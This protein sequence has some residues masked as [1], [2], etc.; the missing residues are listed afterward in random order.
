VI[1]NELP[2][3]SL[4]LR[5]RFSIVVVT[6]YQS[7]SSSESASMILADRPDKPALAPT[8]SLLTDENTV[9]VNIVPVPGFHGSP[10]TSYNIQIDDG[11]GG[12][13][14]EL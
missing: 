6:A 13:F 14:I 12:A 7:V 1:V 3:N 5:F 11:Q 10:I 2:A 4:G 8:R 9:A